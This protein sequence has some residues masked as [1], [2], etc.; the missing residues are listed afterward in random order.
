VI[1]G[2][3]YSRGLTMHIVAMH[4]YLTR[5]MIEEIRDVTTL[6]PILTMEVQLVGE[7]LRTFIT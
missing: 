6:V 3:G 1:N 7:T 2:R 4:D 5:V